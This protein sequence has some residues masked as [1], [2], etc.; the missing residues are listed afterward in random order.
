MLT[1][2]QILSKKTISKKKFNNY[3]DSEELKNV[4]GKITGVSL[5]PVDIK[6]IAAQESSDFYNNTMSGLE[7]APTQKGYGNTDKESTIYMGVTNMLVESTKYAS[8]WIRD[9]G[10][11]INYEKSSEKREKPKD[12]IIV[13][14]G[15][16]G[17]NYDIVKTAFKD[18]APK[19]IDAKIIALNSL[20]SGGNGVK[21]GLIATQKKYKNDA[22]LKLSYP[23]EASYVYN[24]KNWKDNMTDFQNI[25]KQT[26][27]NIPKFLWR[28]GYDI[29]MIDYDSK[30]NQIDSNDQVALKK[31]YSCHK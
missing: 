14:A 26:N 29:R 30:G 31:K 9:H 25:R 10:L 4:L 23:S 28:L 2:K 13:T 27:I 21:S 7:D 24:W 1:K 6:T 20:L 8:D 17:F 12:C 22:S 15:Y 19:G 5:N 3:F 11:T 16:L 18:N